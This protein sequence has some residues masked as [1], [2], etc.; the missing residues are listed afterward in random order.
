MTVRRIVIL[1]V[2]FEDN[3]WQ[4]YLWNCYVQCSG[5]R[6]TILKI[7]GKFS[8]VDKGVSSSSR[9]DGHKLCVVIGQNC[10]QGSVDTMSML[11][12]QDADNYQAMNTVIYM[13]GCQMMRAVWNNGLTCLWMSEPIT[14]M[15]NTAKRSNGGL[16][17]STSRWGTIDGASIS[18]VE[19]ML[20]NV[21]YFRSNKWMSR[22]SIEAGWRSER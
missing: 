16:R 11:V 7:T 1:V 6:R 2:E 8:S 22:C 5:E 13:L 10:R 15:T 21:C 19:W 14:Y 12:R 20:L 4:A 9:G 3:E 18:V 17:R